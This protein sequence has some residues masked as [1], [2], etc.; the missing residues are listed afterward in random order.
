MTGSHEVRGS[1]PL[2]STKSV[3]ALCEI[4]AQAEEPRTKSAALMKGEGKINIML[5]QFGTHLVH[6]ANS[7]RETGD[8]QTK[9]GLSRKP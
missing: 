2:S 7:K 8:R 6:T 4:A 3:S 1:I 9:S 5:A